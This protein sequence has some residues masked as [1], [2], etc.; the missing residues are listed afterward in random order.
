MEKVVMEKAIGANEDDFVDDAHVVDVD[1]ED[2]DVV[3]VAVAEDDDV[4]VVH[5]LRGVG[6]HLR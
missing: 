4:D 3:V 1:V 6:S 2:A 5:P